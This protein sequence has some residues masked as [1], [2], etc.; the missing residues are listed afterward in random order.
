LNLP[1]GGRK[2]GPVFHNLLANIL[3]YIP[4]ITASSPIYEERLGDYVDNRLYFYMNNQN[5]I[6]SL[7]GDVIPEYVKSTEEYAEK[8][9][10][11]YSKDLAR[12][13]ADKCIIG[14]EWINS[15]GAVFRFD[16][17]AIEIRIIDEQDC[18]KSDVAIACLIRAAM[19]GL[20]N[21][22]DQIELLPHDLLVRD[23]RSV[24]KNGLEAKVLH[25]KGPTARDVCR[26]LLKITH[27]NSSDEEKAYLPI[28]RRRIE[29]GNL[30]K[31][32]AE[33]VRQRSQKTGTHEAI[34]RTYQDLTRS[35]IDNRPFF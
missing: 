16:R 35:L 28:V 18:I 17:H 27:S 1:Y 12:A 13:N 26:H 14:V 19:R 34:V 33:R 2:K 20:L 31:T 21:E 15:R 9:I 11:Q 25:P 3:P 30:S 8:V 4:A 24:A 29:E 7:V 6:P 23:F 10:G 32:I 5:E 22:A